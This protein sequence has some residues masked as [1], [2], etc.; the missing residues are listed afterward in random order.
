MD[1]EHDNT[2]SMTDRLDELASAPS[3]VVV[4]EAKKMIKKLI[5]EI[6]ELTERDKLLTAQN[7]YL[8]S[9]VRE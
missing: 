2:S 5:L 8:I 3:Y 4:Y 1:N 6:N 9:K 7:E